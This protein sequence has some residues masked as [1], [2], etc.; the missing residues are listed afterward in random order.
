MKQ[1]LLKICFAFLTASSLWSC[2]PEIYTP[3][4]IEN[5]K[6]LGKA[7]DRGVTMEYEYNILQEA[8]NHEYASREKK[9]GTRVVAIKVT[10]N[11]G[12]PINFYQDI[13]IYAGSRKVTFIDKDVAYKKLRQKSRKHLWYL[14][15][16]LIWIPT[17]NGNDLFPLGAVVGGGITVY[18]VTRTRAQNGKFRREL[19][20]RDLSRREIKDGKTA[21]GLI[22][23]RDTRFVPLSIKAF[24]ADYLP[25]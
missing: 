10:N 3:L 5:T 20:V 17:D 11:S 1:L 2:A 9:T 14:L 4:Y 6:Y 21:Y 23:I 19:Y 25:D 12:V 13:N 16:S 18:R 15:L 8:G 22:C 24:E 7:E